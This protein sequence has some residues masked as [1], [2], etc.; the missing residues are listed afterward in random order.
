MACLTVSEACGAIL[1]AFL[2]PSTSSL[3]NGPNKPISIKGGHL[4][5]DETACMLIAGDRYT[6][7]SGHQADTMSKGR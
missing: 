3:W 7:E 6:P 4:V 2:K 5:D 1:K